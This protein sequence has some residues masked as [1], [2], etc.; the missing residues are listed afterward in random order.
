M[1]ISGV[2]GSGE[3]GGVFAQ[4]SG[5]AAEGAAATGC[6]ALANQATSG[7]LAGTA[8]ARR[9]AARARLVPGSPIV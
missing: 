3:S 5:E 9:T 4:G 1:E 6:G 8:S 2:G 7:S